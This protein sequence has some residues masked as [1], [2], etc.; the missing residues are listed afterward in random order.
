MT[1]HYVSLTD[2]SVSFQTEDACHSA[3]C[4]LPRVPSVR[5]QAQ[6][7]GDADGGSR[8]LG[9]DSLSVAV[10]LAGSLHLLLDCPNTVLFMFAETVYVNVNYI[11]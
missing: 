4:L 9:G 11:L 6:C 7:P 1:L 2:D 3:C 10:A 5:A 8:C